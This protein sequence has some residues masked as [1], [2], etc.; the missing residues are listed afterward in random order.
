MKSMLNRSAD[1][2]L[3]SVPGEMV[4]IRS[5]SGLGGE[6][7]RPSVEV[8]EFEVGAARNDGFGDV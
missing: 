2:D 1:K 6:G 5:E 7:E 3:A 4:G 8:G